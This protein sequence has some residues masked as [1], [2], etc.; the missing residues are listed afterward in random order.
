MGGTGNIPTPW[1]QVKSVYQ[2]EVEA[3]VREMLPV[4]TVSLTL[5]NK[6]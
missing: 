4:P 2:G 3:K 1:A 5:T 6:Q